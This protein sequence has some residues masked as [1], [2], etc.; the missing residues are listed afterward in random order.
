MEKFEYAENETN[1]L[2]L[3][4]VNLTGFLATF[5]SISYENYDLLDQIFSLSVGIL[6]TTCRIAS[7]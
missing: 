2:V 7:H 1:A 6:Y 5:S 4:S 3:G